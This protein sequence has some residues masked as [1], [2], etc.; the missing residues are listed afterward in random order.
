MGTSHV[1]ILAQ[2]GVLKSRKGHIGSCHISIDLKELMN[3]SLDT[4][5][6]EPPDS[7]TCKPSGS[8]PWP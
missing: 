2:R 6:L 5:L 4:S 8:T 1:L 3:T 7:A